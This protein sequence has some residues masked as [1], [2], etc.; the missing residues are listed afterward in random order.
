MSCVLMIYKHT[1][2]FYLLLRSIYE[3]SIGI[4]KSFN[5]RFLMDLPRF[6]NF[7]IFRKCLSVCISPNFCVPCISRT[8]ARKGM[9]LYIQLHLDIIWCW[10]DFGTYCSRSSDV[11]RN[12]WFFQH[13]GMG[14]NCVQLYLIR[15]ILSQSF[16]NSNHIFIITIVR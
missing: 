1:K 13:S 9:K 4:V 12:F 3:K 15:I 8:N 11:V 16:W 5:F 6:W 10:L 14:R 2:C 7:A